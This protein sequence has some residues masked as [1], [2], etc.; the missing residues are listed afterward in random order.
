MVQRL[1]DINACAKE[2]REKR[3]LL[4]YGK[5]VYDEYP[6]VFRKYSENRACLAVCLEAEHMNM[7]GFKLA[8]IVARLSL[9]EIIVLTVDGSPHC[10]QLHF[11][12]EEVN[13]IFGR[14]LPVKHLVIEGGEVVEV[15]QRV[16]K[17]ARYL[18]KIKKLLYRE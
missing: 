5:C 3:R 10:V 7:V 9:E 8:S 11:M 12:V 15:D 13:K 16:V 1:I 6:E 14:N 17:T 2:I 18:T 4:I